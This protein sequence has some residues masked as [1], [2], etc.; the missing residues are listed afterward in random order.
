MTEI[1]V[2]PFG[3]NKVI[4]SRHEEKDGVRETRALEKIDPTVRSQRVRVGRSVGASEVEILQWALQAR[5]DGAPVTTVVIEKAP[6]AAHAIVVRGF[7]DTRDKGVRYE[8]PG[9]EFV[10]RHLQ[11][12]PVTDL[13]DWTDGHTLCCLDVDYHDHAPPSRD[14]LDAVVRTKLFP[15]PHAWHFSRGGGLHLFYTQAQPFSATE[16]AAAA[17]LR[18]KSIDP[19]A[20]VELKKIVRG[21]G[22]EFVQVAQVQMTSVTLSAAGGKDEADP[23]E[24]ARWLDDQGMKLGGRYDH[25]QCP[26]WPTPGDKG[27]NSP[28]TIK[29]DGVFCF[30]CQ[31]KGRS[32]QRAKPGHGSWAAILGNPVADD[33]GS[34]IRGLCHWGHAKYVLVHKYGFP[35]ALAKI[36]YRAAVKAYH[37]DRPTEPL[38]PLVDGGPDT[39]NFTRLGTVWATLSEGYTYTEVKDHLATLPAC[40]T[41]DQDGKPKVVKST[42][43]EFDQKKSLRARGY[44]DVEV[45]HGFKAAQPFLAAPPATVVAVPHARLVEKNHVPRYAYRKHRMPEA[46][47]WDLMW[48]IFPGLDRGLI[49]LALASFACAQETRLGMYPFV[50]VHG[51]SGYG[52]TNTIKLAGG[53]YGALIK[54][55]KFVSDMTRYVGAMWDAAQTGPAVLVNEVLKSAAASDRKLTAREALDP[56]LTMTP[57]TLHHKLYLG[58]IPFGRVPAVY[59]TEPKIPHYM[60]A[61]TQLARR[62]REWEVEGRKDRWKDTVPAAG[63]DFGNLHLFRL[64]SREVNAACDAIVSEVVDEFFALPTSWDKIADSLN[65]KTLEESDQFENPVTQLKAFFDLVVKSPDLDP[66]SREGKVYTGGFKEISRNAS[67]ELAQ[68]LAAAYTQFSD[69]GDWTESRTLVSADWSTIVKAHKNVNL[70]LR[71]NGVN[72]YARF[73]VGMVKNPTEVNDGILRSLE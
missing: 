44:P 46:K 48:S 34:M 61:E 8:V 40:M 54:E 60:A 16:L 6:E 26:I 30:D 13:I 18:F 2:A 41:V 62:I 36:A 9:A 31:A 38:A 58:S 19:S 23:E 24:V 10:T 4:V 73:R 14:W 57:D 1:V 35:E 50:F 22:D 37:R 47:A 11:S 66:K 32:L 15:A 3:D 68:D 70:D 21:P 5:K 29:E 69:N 56:L 12:V 71:S 43:S 42:V 25:D 28:V 45:V 17:A 7:T 49:R 53:I 67:G 72:V 64:T 33:V 20:G 55:P 52:K 65:C 59:L 27:T 39:E 63:V 51:S